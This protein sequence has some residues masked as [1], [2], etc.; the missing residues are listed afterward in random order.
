MQDTFR[1]LNPYKERHFSGIV[2]DFPELFPI[3]RNALKRS[4]LYEKIIDQMVL[5]IC[6]HLNPLKRAGFGN[7][8]HFKAVKYRQTIE[9]YYS[10]CSDV[11]SV[12]YYFNS[13]EKRKPCPIKS[14]NTLINENTCR[15]ARNI[16]FITSEFPTP[17][18]GGGNRVL[19]FIK[20]LSRN[21][22]VFLVTKYIPR[23]DREVEDFVMPH[24]ESV[25]KI[26]YLEWGGNQNDILSWLGTVRID[27]VHYEWVASLK[28][29]SHELGRH[30]ILTY[31]ESVSLRLLIDIQRQT[32]S[33]SEAASLIPEFM[34]YLKIEL[35]DSAP[36]DAYI[37][38]TDKD[39]MFF[40][41]LLP[42][43]EYMVL[44]HGVDFSEF[45]LPEADP[46]PNTMLFLGNYRHHPNVEGM[47]FFL[48]EI[49]PEIRKSVPEARIYIVGPNA[50]KELLNFGRDPAIIF[51]GA[52]PDIRPFIQRAE[53]CVAPLISGAGMRGKI[54]DYAAMKRTFVATNI[55]TAGMVFQ[56]GLDYLNANAA[57]EFS[58]KAVR[59]LKDPELRRSMAVRACET[60]RKN[61]DNVRLVD[62]LYRLYTKLEVASHG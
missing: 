51:T 31:M 16:L 20:I 4:L 42:S 56:D 23:Q 9:A 61:Y 37:T 39:A 19:N 35:V 10:F 38:V 49:F 62:L 12:H 18:H 14:L 52:V 11:L 50:P 60:A 29:Y 30:H 59:L 2:K 15:D 27:F 55:A 32:K 28:N 26:P 7:V 41:S 24:C 1:K 5:H 6:M 25:L 45:D 46:E 8:L 3:C 17:L 34:K 54:I 47:K 13:K 44:N 48:Q 36:M 33:Q 58:M 22:R 43:N 57:G 53:L 40:H 21:N